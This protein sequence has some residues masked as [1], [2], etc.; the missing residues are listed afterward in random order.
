MKPRSS[1]KLRPAQI[2]STKPCPVFRAPTASICTSRHLHPLISATP[3][4]PALQPAVY[5]GWSKASSLLLDQ[6]IQGGNHVLLQLS[7][8]PKLKGGK[9]TVDEILG[10]INC[11]KAPSPRFKRYL[12]RQTTCSEEVDACL[13][14]NISILGGINVKVTDFCNY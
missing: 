2:E 11:L 4:F 1:F 5:N 13:T 8:M 9:R 7:E 14:A 6:A 12:A 3:H 10:D